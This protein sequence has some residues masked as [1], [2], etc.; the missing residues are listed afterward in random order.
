MTNKKYELYEYV[1]K[2]TYKDGS[3]SYIPFE[4]TLEELDTTVEYYRS[5]RTVKSVVTS[6]K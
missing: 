1:I 3:V 4:G 5:D 6:Q 2:V